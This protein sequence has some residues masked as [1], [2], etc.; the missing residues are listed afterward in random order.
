V[1][2]T[3][4]CGDGI[5]N[6]CD[7]LR[8]CNDPN[9]AAAPSCAQVEAAEICGDCVDNDGDGQVDYEDRDCCPMPMALRLKRLQL[10]PASLR[11]PGDR[12][13]LSGVYAPFPPATFNPMGQDT[14]IQVSDP[15][16]TVF[17]ASIPARYWHWPSLRTF[18]FRDGK[19][20]FASGLSEG[21]FSIARNGSVTF[22]AR[23]RRAQVAPMDVGQVQ[24]TIGVGDQCSQATTPVFQRRAGFVFP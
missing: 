22:S 21:H 2:S 4:L 18:R 11:M 14:S 23:G 16:G 3:E 10:S 20:R 7:D 19:A 9:C 13:K 5:D 17:C 15:H 8:D 1:P 12:L 6:D 24:V